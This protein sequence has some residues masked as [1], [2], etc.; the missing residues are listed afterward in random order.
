MQTEET[1]MQEAMK[2]A[3]EQAQSVETEETSAHE[4]EV[5]QD[6]AQTETETKEFDANA[7][8]EENEALKAKLADLEASSKS[9]IDSLVRAV[10][11]TENQKKRIEA[12]VE[13][14]VIQEP[15]SVGAIIRSAERI[16]DNIFI[17]CDGKADKVVKAVLPYVNKTVTCI[18]QGKKQEI[19]APGAASNYFLITNYDYKS[20]FSA[21]HMQKLYGAKKMYIMPYNVDFKDYYTNENMI[22]FI[23]S[24]TEPEKSDYSYHLI[25]EMSK[26]TKVLIGDEEDDDDTFRFNSKTFSRVVQEPK[27][28]SGGNAKIEVTEKKFLRPSK[29]LVHVSVNEEFEEEPESQTLD[30]KQLKKLKAEKK[31][32]EKRLKKEEA[33]RIR[34]EKKAEKARLKEQ[35][36][37]GKD[38]KEETEAPMFERGL[39][40][41]EA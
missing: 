11:E 13:R 17:L 3:Q 37:S 19:T 15:E 23:L 30:P 39:A 40:R 35:K 33:K 38:T 2:K 41:K 20:Q 27:K 26:L 22:Q 7:L 6:N 29:T 10:A 1:Q 12:D 14:E 36:K 8:I 28:L 4:H 5:A 21:R 24:N 9:K 16:Y 34:E 31:K 32:E 18:P 25:T